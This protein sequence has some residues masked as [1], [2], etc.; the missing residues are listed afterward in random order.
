M[1]VI[2]WIIVVVAV[3]FAL[4]LINVAGAK[5]RRDQSGRKGANPAPVADRMVRCERCGVYLPQVDARRDGNG[6]ICGDAGCA[7]HR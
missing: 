1:K 4:R 6:F 7:Q 3:L 5:R 2:V